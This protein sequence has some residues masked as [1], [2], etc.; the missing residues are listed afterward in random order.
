MYGKFDEKGKFV[1]ARNKVTHEGN[2]TIIEP[3][4]AEELAAGNYKEVYRAD[5]PGRPGP[6]MRPQ[7]TYED[8]GDFI[9]E[10][11]NWVEWKKP[12]ADGE[13]K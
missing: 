11:T 4:S 2:K 10:R 8:K 6:G 7:R 12:Q 3:M 13:A 1:P 9:L 5:G